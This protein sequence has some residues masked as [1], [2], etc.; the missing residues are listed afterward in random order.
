MH[1]CSNRL[2]VWR[3]WKPRT[4]P[5]SYANTNAYAHS[6]ADAYANTHPG[7]NAYANTHPDADS[8]TCGFR[9]RRV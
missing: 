1:A 6:N 4:D 3:R 2:C 8:L 7:T 5:R 9:D